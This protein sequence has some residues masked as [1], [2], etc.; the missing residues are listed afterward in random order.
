MDEIAQVQYNRVVYTGGQICCRGAQVKKMFLL[1]MS[2]FNSR[3]TSALSRQQP[4]KKKLLNSSMDKE[5]LFN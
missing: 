5:T 3:C 4:E 2:V 1:C